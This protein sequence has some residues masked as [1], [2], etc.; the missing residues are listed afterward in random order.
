M[1]LS[2]HIV[3]ESNTKAPQHHGGVLHLRYACSAVEAGRRQRS[4]KH[5]VADAPGHN[6]AGL[7]ADIVGNPVGS[8]P[9]PT[10]TALH[11]RVG[12]THLHVAFWDPMAIL[13]GVLFRHEDDLAIRPTA[14]A[15]D[16]L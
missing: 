4:L 16:D 13:Y 2:T 9:L 12:P 1:T 7:R 14:V 3:P 15:P 6:R 10:L 8:D 5:C 11:F